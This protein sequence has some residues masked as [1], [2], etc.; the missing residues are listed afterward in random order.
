MLKVKNEIVKVSALGILKS[1]V[2][3]LHQ[4]L[5]C[6]EEDKPV[7]PQNLNLLTEAPDK[8]SLLKRTFDAA[9]IRFAS[10]YIFHN[11]DA[12]VVNNKYDDRNR[13]TGADALQKTK[14]RDHEQNQNHQGVIEA[15]QLE[16]GI[17]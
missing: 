17:I 4:T 6:A 13:D 8:L 16:P 5:G 15:R 2:H 9:L 12:T 11:I 1:T 14:S 10:K 3:T 7:Q